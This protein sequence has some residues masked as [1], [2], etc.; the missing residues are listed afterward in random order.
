MRRKEG[1]CVEEWPRGPHSSDLHILLTSDLGVA[2]LY[3]QLPA[4]TPIPP[5]HTPPSKTEARG[6]LTA[7]REGQPLGLPRSV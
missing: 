1:V 3:P 5:T 2:T 4:S 6:S 7:G